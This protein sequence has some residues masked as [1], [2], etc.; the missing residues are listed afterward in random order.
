MKRTE[1][2]KNRTEG[3]GSRIAEAWRC[4]DLYTRL[5]FV[6]F[7][8]SQCV[9]GQIGK[10]I[11]FLAAEI[12]FVFYMIT[13]GIG[14]LRGLITLG[15]QEQ[16]WVMDEAKGIEILVQG[17]N[18]MLFLLYGVVSLF[19]IAG[20]LIVWKINLNSAYEVQKLQ[21]MGKRIPKLKDDLKA[22]M[23][24]KSYITLLLLPVAGVLI[25]TVMPL[26]YMIMIAFTNYDN[27]H[28]PPGNLFH[29][30]GLSNF[31]TILGSG[32]N[33]GYTFWHILGWTLIWAVVA[34]F[35]CYI[36]GILI[37]LWINSRY[38][39]WKKLWRT[40]FVMSV[41]VPQFVSLLV[42][43]TM[44]QPEGA[45]NIM[46]QSLGLI[47]EKLPFLTDATWARG[48]VLVVNLWLGVPYT[49]LIVTG[50]LMNIPSELYEAASLDGA[51]GFV[52]FRKITMP[53]VLFVTTPYLI[54]QFVGNVNNFNVIYLLTTGGPNTLDY[55]QAGKTDLLVTWL[56]K[57]TVGSKDYS[58]ASTIG[59]LVFVI[60]AVISLLTY[61]RTSASNNEEGFQ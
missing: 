46:L 2:I 18:S 20:F 29:W 39:K 30:T 21:A 36:V 35:S 38:V 4:G 12:A 15:T 56:Y 60:S 42:L 10:G 17:D 25:F 1:G 59:I 26:V 61:R 9:R 22:L 23:D 55:Y 51:S 37:S 31:I 45:V 48:T 3:R 40:I 43:K 6:V 41:A 7:G 11:L 16:G 58:Y 27:A 32:S 24:Q 54:T 34:T 52:L 44:L 33:L 13:T 28:Q 49:M 57:L 14:A 50:I 53:Y 47:N 8:L 5:S 19:I